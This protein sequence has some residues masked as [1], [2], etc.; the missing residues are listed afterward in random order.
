MDIYSKVYQD[1]I[2]RLE[3]LDG[4]SHSLKETRIGGAGNLVRG[5]SAGVILECD[6]IW[7]VTRNEVVDN[8]LADRWLPTNDE[9]PTAVI[10][11]NASGRT[12]LVMHDKRT[13]ITQSELTSKTAVVYYSDKIDL[14]LP[15]KYKLAVQD[16]A[17]TSIEELKAIKPLGDRSVVSISK[18]VLTDEILETWLR[19]GM[20]VVSHNPEMTEI[21]N[22]DKR[23]VIENKFYIERNGFDA[24][25]LGDI[26]TY[27]VAR[28]LNEAADEYSEA[29]RRAQALVGSLVGQVR[30]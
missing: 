21:I 13:K 16:T 7:W 25:G 23:Q 4:N 28:H 9:D 10:V 2:Y 20:V 8:D 6:T 19:V 26:F 3:K 14:A 30:A 5:K 24:T 29:V 27:L 22:G 15:R 11:E 12:S 18:E 1:W 17:G